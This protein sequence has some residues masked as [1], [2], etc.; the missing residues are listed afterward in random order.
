M[1]QETLSENLAEKI[2]QG[3]LLVIDVQQALF[4][5]ST[6][7]FNAGELLE[8]IRALVEKARRANTPVVWVQ[9]QNDRML[10]EGTDGWKLHP[11]LQPLTDELHIHK[12]HGSAFEKTI[13]KHELEQRGIRTLVASGLVT[14]GCV[15]ATCL[16]GKAL[17]YRVILA[18]DA[19]SNYHKQADN[20]IAEWHQNLS[21][22]GIEL[23]ATSQIDFAEGIS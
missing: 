21:E 15:K 5:R 8:N 23:R 1:K 20:V 2:Q 3:A 10:A 4:Q 14:Q 18:E 9:H 7:I 16:A 22:A 13:L 6:P 12:Q 11:R 17:G 19:H